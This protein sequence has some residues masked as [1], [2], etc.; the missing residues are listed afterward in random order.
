MAGQVQ[1][2]G[3]A[4]V[5]PKVRDGQDQ[6]PPGGGHVELG[7]LQ[8]K[9]FLDGG[10]HSAG[11]VQE[12]QHEV[13][14]HHPGKEVGEEHHRLVGLGGEA[15]FEL[16]HHHRQRHRQHQHQHD[17]DPVVERRV[18]D[19]RHRGGALQER[20]VLQAHPLRLRQVVPEGVGLLGLVVLESDHHA[21]HRKIPY[22]QQPD[23]AG[24]DHRQ[25]PEI[26][27]APPAHRSD[28][29]AY[30]LSFPVA[31]GIITIT[32]RKSSGSAWLILP[33]L[34]V[35]EKQAA[36]IIDNS[37]LGLYHAGEGMTWLLCSGGNLPPRRQAW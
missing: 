5:L 30:R 16:T 35:F 18:A 24:K 4:H 10:D 23:R 31:N 22:Q 8:P 17:P 36:T 37:A 1:H 32:P 25:Q 14:C 9:G 6:R 20:E 13:A 34:G 21:Q 28:L 11:G 7:G 26:L 15:V 12:G 29:H 3:V 19:H 33:L 2:A 27:P